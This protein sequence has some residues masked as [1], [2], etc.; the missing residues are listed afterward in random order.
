M[1]AYTHFVETMPESLLKTITDRWYHNNYGDF[2]AR[3]LTGNRREV[4]FERGVKIIFRYKR[5]FG[6][7]EAETSHF[8]YHRRDA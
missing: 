8:P 2:Q 6:W 1:T 5:S 7:I 4:I 3:I